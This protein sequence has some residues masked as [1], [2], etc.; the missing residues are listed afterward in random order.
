VEVTVSDL[1]ALEAFLRRRLAEPLPG[2][3]AHQR[4]A[5]RPTR[6]GWRPDDR[7][8]HA[9][10]AAALILIYPGDVGPVLALTVRHADLPHHPGQISLP[11]GRID[12]DESAEHAALR[13]THEEIGVQPS[14]VRVLGALSTLWVVVSNQLVQPF[15]GLTD[16]RPTFVLAAREV[17]RLIEMPLADLH[18]VERIGW[19]R[20]T[21]DGEPIDYPFFRLADTQ[22][23]GATAMMLGEFGALFNPDF[24]PTPS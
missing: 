3:V 5:P 2:A 4:F 11:G 1:A 14:A 16:A 22:V 21:R 12:L 6:D 19:E 23:W 24:G 20:R 7:P 8:P 10:R 17:E 18:D 9:R 15:V 13:E